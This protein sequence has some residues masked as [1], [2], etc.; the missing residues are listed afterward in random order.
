MQ[1]DVQGLAAHIDHT[2]LYHQLADLISEETYLLRLVWQYLAHAI[3]DGGNYQDVEV[4]IARGCPLSPLMAALYLRPLD[5][6]LEGASVHYARFMDDWVA[7]FPT[8]WRLRDGVK[9]ANLV[10]DDLLVAKHPD[11]TYIGRAASGFDFLGYRITAEELAVSEAAL[12]RRDERVVRLY[13]QGAD[14]NRIEQY[15]SRWQGWAQGGL[16]E[17]VVI[18]RPAAQPSALKRLGQFGVVGAGLAAA[19]GASASMIG[20][21]ASVTLPASVGATS[22]HLLP[23]GSGFVANLFIQGVGFSY[24][25][26]A[27]MNGLLRAQG[28]GWMFAYGSPASVPPSA[29][30]SGPGSIDMWAITAVDGTFSSSSAAAQA[31]FDFI[32]TRSLRAYFSNGTGAGWAAVTLDGPTRTSS[33]SGYLNTDGG[34]I[35]GTDQPTDGAPAPAPPALALMVTGMALM[36]L[37]AR[38]RRAVRQARAATGGAP[39]DPSAAP[40]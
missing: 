37:L 39:R 26:F 33:V 31:A 34:I 32:G 10:L 9:A 13:E 7:L 21:S 24:R 2:T 38:R 5:Q 20:L 29:V 17:P 6:A 40:R 1:S 12:Q 30:P 8:R 23:L 18:P 16:R 22:A 11:K 36:P 27:S 4:G 19:A 3:E 35:W 15:L 14:A 25:G 28:G